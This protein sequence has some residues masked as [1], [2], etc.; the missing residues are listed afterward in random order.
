MAFSAPF[1]F[2]ESVSNC[3]IVVLWP[4]SFN[5][6]VSVKQRRI[7]M[8]FCR[9][10]VS[11]IFCASKNILQS[12]KGQYSVYT[13][14]VQ[15]GLQISSLLKRHN[16]PSTGGMLYFMNLFGF[17]TLL[18]AL[19]EQLSV[20]DYFPYSF[21][22]YFWPVSVHVTVP[23]DSSNHL[24]TFS[25]AP[26]KEKTITVILLCTL[27]KFSYVLFATDIFIVDTWLFV[28]FLGKIRFLGWFDGVACT[29]CTCVFVSSLRCLDWAC[30]TCRTVLWE[31]DSMSWNLVYFVW[32]NVKDSLYLTNIP[33]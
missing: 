16:Q 33:L 25:R 22:S 23:V 7:Q 20:T 31:Q 11:C 5:S 13:Y 19:W 10:L 17:I 30:A 32:R 27:L 24:Q 3:L 12:R 9:Q 14:K 29:F 4:I 15:K 1:D 6:T 28:F 26:C 2:R 8:L 18:S 21:E